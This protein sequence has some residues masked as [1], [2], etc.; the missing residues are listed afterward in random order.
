VAAISS[1]NSVVLAFELEKRKSVDLLGFAIRRHNP[2]GTIIWLEGLL[3]FPGEAHNIG[4]PLT[5]NEAPLQKLFWSDYHVRPDQQYEYEIIPVFGKPGALKLDTSLNIRIKIE[6][7][8]GERNHQVFFNRAVIASQAYT[9]NFGL[10][11][12]D[13]DERILSWLARG[14]DKAIV[15]FI[16]EAGKDRQLQLDMAAYHL[17]H[18]G[19]ID[20]LRQV[21]SRARLCLH[22]KK[23]GDE[24]EAKKAAAI[25]SKAGVKIFKREHVAGLSHS[26]FIVLKNKFGKAQSVL[27]GSTNFTTGGICKQNNVSHIIRDVNIAEK[28]AA[29]FD[30]QIQDNSR[31]LMANNRKWLSASNKFQVNFSPHVRGQ[32]V[33]LNYI[34]E[35][36]KKAKSSIFFA[37]FRMTD[38][39][40]IKALLKPS[41]KEIVVRGLVDSVHKTGAEIA[42]YHEAGQKDPDVVP[43]GN[44]SKKISHMSQELG[45]SGFSPIVH[46]KFIILDFNT[47]DCTVITGSANYSNNS[48]EKN[49]EN[50]LIIRRDSQIAD[51]YFAEFVRLYE[52][53]RSR[54]MIMR[55]RKEDAMSLTPD[56][57]WLK[58]YNEKSMSSA[59]VKLLL[60]NN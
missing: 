59:F 47:P 45:R 39:D 60:K 41:S 23:E 7:R 19:V 40:L 14:L 34:T 27:M 21:G 22:W 5:T 25:L 30:L 6:T 37:T 28:Y 20:A 8:N 49:D 15:S 51:M 52:H 16:E 43:A 55:S 18:P 53:Y 48:T 10:V 54:S 4:E 31:I 38:A 35:L 11:P 24:I 29:T 9:R 44:I 17:D 46:H 13:K 56:D 33:D 42:L 57:S 3:S 2:D 1:A 12:P 36:V 58:K 32:P 50:T 26:K